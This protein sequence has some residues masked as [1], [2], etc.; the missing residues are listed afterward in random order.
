M[1]LGEGGS[2]VIHSC[3]LYHIL[4]ITYDRPIQ[5]NVSCYVALF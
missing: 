4:F 3:Y 1:C 2:V 5:A